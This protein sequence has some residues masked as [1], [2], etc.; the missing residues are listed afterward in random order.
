MNFICL[1]C[2]HIFEDGE[3]GR[4]TETY[5]TG[6]TPLRESHLVCP[7]CGGAYDEAVYCKTCG[8][9]IP[10]SEAVFGECV[11]CFNREEDEE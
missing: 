10:L 11:D 6:M 5:D 2:G 4:I 8:K 7:L 1:E 9:I 3:Q